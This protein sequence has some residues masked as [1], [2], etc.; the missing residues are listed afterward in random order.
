MD[1]SLK[2]TVFLAY[3]LYDFL[4]WES[5]GPREK[6]IWM[7]FCFNARMRHS[8]FIVTWVN[9]QAV[10][11]HPTVGAVNYRLTVYKRPTEK[12]AC[13]L[14]SLC[15]CLQIRSTVLLA[16]LHFTLACVAV[17]ACHSYL[18]RLAAFQ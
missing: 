11:C 14:S 8:V 16:R 9:F 7:Q 15:Q 17:D 4:K 5:Q 2:G 6:G 12:A 18:M 1:A 13:Q 10:C 3:L